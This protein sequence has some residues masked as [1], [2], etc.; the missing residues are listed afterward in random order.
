MG[1]YHSS[2]NM[3]GAN[4]HLRHL[5]D[6]LRKK[7]LQEFYDQYFGNIDILQRFGTEFVKNLA[8]H[9]HGCVV[10]PDE[11]YIL[12]S[13]QSNCIFF[14]AYGLIEIITDL[15]VVEKALPE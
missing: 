2:V 12:E 15:N 13:S 5:S 8:E 9:F 4:K 7:V 3:F 11:P 10:A 6:N 1:Y 14:L